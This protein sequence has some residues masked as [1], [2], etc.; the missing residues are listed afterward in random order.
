MTRDIVRLLANTES[1]RVWLLTAGTTTNNSEWK[2]R[3]RTLVLMIRHGETKSIDETPKE[4]LRPNHHHGDW[5]ASV[6]APM[7][8]FTLNRLRSFDGGT[9]VSSTLNFSLLRIPPRSKLRNQSSKWSV[10]RNSWCFLAEDT[11][12]K[13]IGFDGS[14]MGNHSWCRSMKMCHTV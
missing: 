5:G 8:I 3:P 14:N 10:R 1:P 12:I 2:P 6:T 4:P 11:I 13:W 9:S 7:G